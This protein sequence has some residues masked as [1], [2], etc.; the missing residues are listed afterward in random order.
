MGRKPNMGCYNY[1]LTLPS[2]P[3]NF[4]LKMDQIQTDIYRYFFFLGFRFGHG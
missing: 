3:S 1:I 2:S 4:S